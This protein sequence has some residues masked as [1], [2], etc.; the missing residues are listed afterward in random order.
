[1]N[2]IEYTLID[3]IYN[4]I[5]I[6]EIPSLFSTMCDMIIK[7]FPISQ[8]ENKDKFYNH[9]FILLLKLDDFDIILEGIERIAEA[10]IEV[11]YKYRSIL[12]SKID[13]FWPTLNPGK[14]IRYIEFLHFIMANL[15]NDHPFSYYEMKYI[16]KIIIKGIDSNI[17][18]VTEQSCKII[19]D[20]FITLLL[21]Y[22]DLLLPIM[23]ALQKQ[24]K[25]AINDNTRT[26]CRQLV[27]LLI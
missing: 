2:I 15:L 7:I 22:P 19:G 23:N 18:K 5:E 1:M 27:N 10:Y 13:R 12:L 6:N 14:Q 24:A 3:I 17:W 26:V 20:D 16:Q 21:S 4:V 25:R 9:C 8:T 11:D